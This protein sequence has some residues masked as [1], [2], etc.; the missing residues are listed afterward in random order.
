MTPKSVVGYKQR[1][2][3]LFSRVAALSYDSELQAHWA[4]Y[5]CVLVSGFLEVSVSALYEEYARDTANANTADYVS[6]QLS[7]FRNPNMARI[8]ELTRRFSRQWEE[9]LRMQTQGQLK[10]AVDSIV[11]LR[12]QIA[13]GVYTTLTYQRMWSYYACVV[14]VVDLIDR[15]RV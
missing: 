12:N 7:R 10:D 6:S 3:H 13:H 11:A 14:K 15:L 2:D 5:L 4:C 1:L 8:L 9:C